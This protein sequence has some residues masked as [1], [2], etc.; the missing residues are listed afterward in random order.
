MRMITP[1]IGGM[2]ELSPQSFGQCVYM[3]GGGGIKANLVIKDHL[4]ERIK[5]SKL[6][7]F[8]GIKIYLEPIPQW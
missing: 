8:S 6:I 5:L 7:I 2:C 1:I 3:Y 4:L